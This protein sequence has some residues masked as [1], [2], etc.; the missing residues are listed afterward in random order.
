VFPNARLYLSKN[1][2]TEVT[3]ILSLYPYIYTYWRSIIPS[4]SGSLGGILNRGV[5]YFYNE[6]QTGGK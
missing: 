3:I 2:Q 1:R 5:Q 6:S 4:T